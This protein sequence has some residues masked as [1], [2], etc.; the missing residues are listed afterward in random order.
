LPILVTDLFAYDTKAIIDIAVH[1]SGLKEGTVDHAVHI[2]V[3]RPANGHASI[4]LR[5]TQ[6]QDGVTDI[7]ILEQLDPRAAA[8]VAAALREATSTATDDLKLE[9]VVDAAIR[10]FFKAEVE[11]VGKPHLDRLLALIP[12]AAEE[13]TIQDQMEEL[14]EDL[15][16][17]LG[18]D[19]QGD[20]DR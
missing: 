8:D 2:P 14:M 3:G 4:Y 7:S 13:V 16:K 15:G 18:G 5:T 6:Y 1:P 19:T 11:R 12:Q 17:E 20:A 9:D 10:K